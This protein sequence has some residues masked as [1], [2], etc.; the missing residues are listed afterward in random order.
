MVNYLFIFLK[1]I[2]FCTPIGCP[3]IYTF[4]SY[5]YTVLT[6]KCQF[7][8]LFNDIIIHFPTSIQYIQGWLDEG[9]IVRP[10]LFPQIIINALFSSSAKKNILLIF[11][12]NFTLCKIN[13]IILLY[14]RKLC[15]FFFY[16]TNFM[17]TTYYIGNAKITPNIVFATLILT[18]PLF[19][20]LIRI[21]IY[22]YNTYIPVYSTIYIL[23]HIIDYNFYVLF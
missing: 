2:H 12:L 15:L 16:K 17:A 20:L 7:N 23:A 13:Q 3:I 9:T 5:L 8:F 11:F 19:I 14:F 4:S 1:K 10:F 6:L 22:T 18:W 21:I